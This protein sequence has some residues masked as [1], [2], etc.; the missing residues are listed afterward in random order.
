ML[1]Q[2]KCRKFLKVSLTWKSNAQRMRYR[3][4]NLKTYYSDDSVGFLL[5]DVN[6]GMEDKTVSSA[7]FAR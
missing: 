4:V 2:W 7:T 5:F 6:E 3:F 1:A